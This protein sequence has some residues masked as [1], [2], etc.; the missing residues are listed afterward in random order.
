MP[1]ASPLRGDAHGIT[2][3]I[4][5]SDTTRFSEGFHWWRFN[6]PTDHA[7][8]PETPHTAPGP[9]IGPARRAG[10]HGAAGRGTRVP[11]RAGATGDRG[12][13][14][15]PL[16]GHRERCAHR[17]TGDRTR[18]GTA[19]RTRRAARHARPWHAHTPGSPGR[20]ARAHSPP[21]TRPYSQRCARR[22]PTGYW[23]PTRATSSIRADADQPG[24]RGGEPEPPRGT[25]A[26]RPARDPRTRSAGRWHPP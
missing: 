20:Y 23:W 18:P 6:M 21:T 1:R 26:A 22:S 12:V 19:T 3:F 13:A 16:Q 2:A 4:V 8:E 5:P 17:G 10:G 7:A 15:F 14:G 11:Q 25:V 24:A 9:H